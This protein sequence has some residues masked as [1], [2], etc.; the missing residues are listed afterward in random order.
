MFVFSSRLIVSV[1]ASYNSL[2]R[3][4]QREKCTALREYRG[5]VEKLSRFYIYTENGEC[6]TFLL[7][8]FTYTLKRHHT[9]IP[10]IVQY[11]SIFS[12]GRDNDN[13]KLLRIESLSL[14]RVFSG[15]TSETDDY[16]NKIKITSLARFA[17]VRV[18]VKIFGQ[19][20]TF[21]LE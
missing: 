11:Y 21:L 15:H 19:S 4:Q 9:M 2:A 12:D 17:V 14:F 20:R 5:R 6:S 1:H 16:Q 3:V 10:I 8:Q 18:A 13:A 7:L